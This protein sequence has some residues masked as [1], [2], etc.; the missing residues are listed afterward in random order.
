[1]LDDKGFATFAGQPIVVSGRLANPDAAD[2]V[3]VAKE[4]ADLLHLE[5]GDS[6]GFTAYRSGEYG[7]VPTGP[8]GRLTVVGIVRTPRD[9]VAGLDAG[10]SVVSKASPY[11]GPGVLE[12]LRQRS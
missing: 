10:A 6:A 7:G 9:L 4:T 1:M 8:T 11:A 3:V 5:V 12:A 2:E